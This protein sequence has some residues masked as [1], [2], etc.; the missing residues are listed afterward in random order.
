MMK[1]RTDFCEFLFGGLTGKVNKQDDKAPG[2]FPELCL[3]FVPQLLPRH[4]HRAMWRPHLPMDL[5]R[6][7]F[8][9]FISFVSPS[10]GE[11]DQTISG[12]K[13]FILTRFAELNIKFNST[14]ELK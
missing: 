10:N 9:L 8:C 11:F 6:F 13:E 5:L 1:K 2:C 7:L 3:S 12:R 14:N 4:P